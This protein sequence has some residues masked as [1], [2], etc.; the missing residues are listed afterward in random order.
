MS[1]FE[2]APT[3]QFTISG[4]ELET[5]IQVLTTKLTTPEAQTII[6]EYETLKLLQES[7]RKGVDEGKV[8]E[9]YPDT[10]MNL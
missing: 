10:S 6:K 8:R 5:V 1:T 7:V 4:F 2:W 3:E 9:N